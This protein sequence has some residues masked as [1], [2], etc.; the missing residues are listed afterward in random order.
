MRHVHQRVPVCFQRTVECLV[1]A[2]HLLA[3]LARQQV[4]ARGRGADR[5]HLVERRAQHLLFAARFA[6]LAL[7]AA[8]VFMKSAAAG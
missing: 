7:A 1:L 8:R 4:K 3:L 5:V 2:E 6:G